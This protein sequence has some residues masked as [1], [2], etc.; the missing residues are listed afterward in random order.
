MLIY[1]FN[2]NWNILE[3][4]SSPRSRRKL[5]IFGFDS[6]DDVRLEKTVCSLSQLDERFLYE[7]HLFSDEMY[8]NGDDVLDLLDSLQPS[9]IVNNCIDRQKRAIVDEAVK[10]SSYNYIYI[11]S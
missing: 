5:A 10:N 4:T 7:I 8:S 1:Y 2:R 11:I 6:Y 3:S 9:A